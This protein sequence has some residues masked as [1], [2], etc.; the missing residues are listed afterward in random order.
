MI[1]CLEKVVIFGFLETGYIDNHYSKKRRFL[2][3]H[4]Y[5]YSCMFSL[6]ESSYLEKAK[7]QNRSFHRRLKKAN[8]AYSGLVW[9]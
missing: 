2:I 1:R 9:A 8:N 5:K 6:Q 7:K 4:F 3:K